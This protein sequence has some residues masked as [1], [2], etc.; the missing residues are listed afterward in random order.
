M[1]SED[2]DPYLRDIKTVDYSEVDEN[3]VQYAAGLTDAD[4]SFKC[5][6]NGKTNLSLQFS[7]SQS[8]KGMGALIYIHD[9]FGGSINLQLEGD[10][11]NQR[12]YSWTLNG[13]DAK[14][15]AR[16]IVDHLLLKKREAVRF[17]E[18]PNQNLHVIP[19]TAENATTGE[20]LVFDTIKACAAHFG[21]ATFSF[22]K[23]EAIKL[24]LWMIK[25]TL[26]KKDIEEIMAKRLQIA[27]DLKRFK[28]E[29]HADIPVDFVPSIPYVASFFD[30]DGTVD[31]FGKFGQRHS[32]NQA[33][34]A[35]CDLFQRNFGGKVLQTKNIFRWQIHDGADEFLKQVAPFVIGKKQQVDMVL[36]MKPGEG[37][38]VHAALRHL[39]GKGNMAT[40]AIDRYVAGGS[41]FTA[42]KV[43][44]KGVFQD[45]AQNPNIVFVQI[46]YKKKVYRLKDFHI[47]D[48]DQAT[49]LYKKTKRAIRMNKD[50][51]IT[52]YHRCNDKK[53]R[54]C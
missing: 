29:V 21:R 3:A 30:G 47:D 26:S 25:K 50:Y 6:F 51:E 49:E 37:E 15:F 52:D 32:I 7:L 20:V 33:S 1:T 19:I 44:P 40:A 54:G 46:Q 17:I 38:K 28:N 42:T 9:N 48:L 39:K 13:E 22:Q 45:K 36:A 18:F 5:N 24:G 31:A 53:S 4:G 43:F 2:V 11:K 16:L 35:I 8:L 14:R 10:E 34:V 23:V 41:Q 27:E 12:A